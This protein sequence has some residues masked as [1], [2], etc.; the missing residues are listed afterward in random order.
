M[1]IRRAAIHLVELALDQFAPV[2][3]AN[4]GNRVK[5]KIFF[6]QIDQYIGTQTGPALGIV[7]EQRLT[8]SVGRKRFDFLRFAIAPDDRQ[9]MLIGQIQE[10]LFKHEH[11]S[12]HRTNTGP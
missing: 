2:V 3:T 9:K 5:P 11:C 4:M 1:P 8:R 12:K 10:V 6:D 7:S